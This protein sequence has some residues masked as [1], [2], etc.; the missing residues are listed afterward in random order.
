V[1][2]PSD[3]WSRSWSVGLRGCCWWPMLQST[4]WRGSFLTSPRSVCGRGGPSHLLVGNG[5]F[6]V[7]RVDGRLHSVGVVSAVNGA[8]E[9]DYRTRIRG[10]TALTAVDDLHD[11]L[12]Q[13]KATRGRIFAMHVLRQKVPALAHAEA[14]AYVNALRSGSAPAHQTIGRTRGKC[15]RRGT[16][17][18][19]RWLSSRI[20]C[21]CPAA[22][23]RLMYCATA[24]LR[25]WR[26]AR[27]LSRGAV[28]P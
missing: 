16:G 25:L 23:R 18:G 7:D 10:M 19:R 12:R 4:N 26:R 2:S 21:R 20:G 27:S 5:P 9:S 13:T 14:I 3:W 11:E 1:N 15:Q 6:L 28:V 24:S 8:W 17:P 22:E